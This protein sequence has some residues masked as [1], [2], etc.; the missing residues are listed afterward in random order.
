MASKIKK[1]L[2][3]LFLSILVLIN[4]P[5]NVYTISKESISNITIISPQAEEVSWYYR[6]VIGGKQ[7][8][9]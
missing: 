8:R 4:I 9:L 1:A 2:I 6:Y 5:N 7:M 3:Y